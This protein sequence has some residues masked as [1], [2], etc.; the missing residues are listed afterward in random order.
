MNL[1]TL[2]KL[3]SATADLMTI[4]AIIV[5]AVWAWY[6]FLRRRE[7]VWNLQIDCKP[8]FAPYGDNLQLLTVY[9]LLSNIGQVRLLPIKNGCWF[10]LKKLPEDS[11]AGSTPH[12]NEG[13]TI[14]DKYDVIIKAN[15]N[16]Y[17]EYIEDDYWLE[18]GAR[19]EEVV[20]VVVPKDITVMA[21]AG[22]SGKEGEEIWTY[23]VWQVPSA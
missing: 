9:I 12:W 17:E 6:R 13:E 3:M 23:R 18:P 20:N 19:Y 21:E 16:H 7:N 15:P 10:S 8:S 4:L 5:G 1:D 14:L 22:F 11:A 2:M